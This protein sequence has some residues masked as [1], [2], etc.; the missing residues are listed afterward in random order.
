[1]QQVNTYTFAQ[2]SGT[3]TE[4]AGDT[5]VASATSTGTNPIRFLDDV[6]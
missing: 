5:V 4:I 3:Y 2:T 1:M 6:V